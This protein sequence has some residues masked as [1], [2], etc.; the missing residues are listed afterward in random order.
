MNKSNLIEIYGPIKKELLQI[1]KRLHTLLS[2]DADKY[3]AEIGNYIL[4]KPGKRLRPALVLLSAR[5]GSSIK[6][7]VIDL[8][9]AIELIH[10]ATLIHDDIIDR[11][12]KRRSQKS[13]NIKYGRD[14]A[15]LFGDFLYSKAFELIASLNS[16]P[17]IMLLLK[18]AGTIC[19]GEI[20]QLHKPQN[21]IMKINDYLK[22]IEEKTA[23]LFATCCEAGAILS[24]SSGKNILALKQYGHNLGMGFQII[25]DYLDMAG[26]EPRVGKEVAV[27]YCN[28]AASK[29][30]GI[31]S[32]AA[33]SSLIKLSGFVLGQAN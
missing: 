3:V 21:S 24:G 28:L 4:K 26:D 14:A 18:N 29:L 7:K 16:V 19:R 22:I 9:A 17:I 6:P 15:I 27:K 1:E 30:S 5:L 23:S 33:K 10:T 12:E 32:S 20:E 31:R 11:A 2:R 25:D 13:V 8:A